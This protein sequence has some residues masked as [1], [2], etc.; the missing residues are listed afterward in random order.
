MYFQTEDI[1]LAEE[2]T[3]A[4]EKQYI[5]EGKEP[6]TSHIYSKMSVYVFI[7]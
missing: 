4:E 6:H 3:S 5:M 2:R 1:I 7:I